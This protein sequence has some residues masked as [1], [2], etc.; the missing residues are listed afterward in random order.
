M[1]K[2]SK[3]EA[4]SFEKTTLEMI[5]PTVDEAISRGLNQLGLPREAVDVEVLDAGNKGL[6]GL[7]G[8][9]A[10]VR[11]TIRNEEEEVEAEE[12]QKPESSAPV[13]EK[14]PEVANDTTKV[15]VA[16]E[17]SVLEVSKTV[18]MDLLE[19]MKVHARVS[20]HYVQPDGAGQQPTVMIEIQGD[21]LS[22]LIGRR[23]ETLNALQYITGLIVGKE[24]GH[25][26]HLLIDVQGYRSRRDRQLRQL[27]VRLAD[28]VARTGRRQTLE[29]MPANERR[30]IH[31]ELRNH[32]LV[33]TESIGEEPN[34]KVTIILKK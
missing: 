15:V 34:R 30:I 21:D 31:L 6:F 23:S 20:A 13:A 29:P 2:S 8:R 27:A 1:P 28:Q 14:K 12:P 19:K 18:V 11:L 25:W 5:A 7:G 17:E 10:R 26:V 16:D 9:Q 33:T 32:P 4:M 24:I 22:Y 3:R